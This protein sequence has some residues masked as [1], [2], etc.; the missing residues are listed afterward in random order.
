MALIECPECGSEVSSEAAACPKCGHPLRAKPSGGIN[1][2]DPVHAIGVILL[3][4][5]LLIGV[6]SGIAQCNGS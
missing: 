3:V 5:I 2:K 4:I 6:G 1:M